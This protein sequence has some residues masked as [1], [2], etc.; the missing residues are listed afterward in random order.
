M[1]TEIPQETQLAMGRTEA[2]MSAGWVYVSSGPTAG[3]S[4]DGGPPLTVNNAY[5]LQ[6]YWDTLPEGAD[7]PEFQ[8][9]L[10]GQL[11]WSKYEQM[12]A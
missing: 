10:G 4:K 2:I 1:S 7:D 9:Y 12:I 6:A 11:D 8:A 3:F 5:Y